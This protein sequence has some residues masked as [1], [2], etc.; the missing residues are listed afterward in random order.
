MELHMPTSLRAAREIS[1]SSV[2]AEQ[3]RLIA[4]LNRPIGKSDVESRTLRHTWRPWTSFRLGWAFSSLGACLRRKSQ[5]AG[6]IAGPVIILYALPGFASAQNATWLAAPSTSDFNT[7]T[8]WTP[9]TVPTGT[10]TFGP[11]SISSLTFSQDTTVGALQFNAPNYTFEPTNAV[12]TIAIS[13]VGILVANPANSPTFN[14]YLSA[15]PIRKLEH[16]QHG[17]S[18]R[19]QYRSYSLP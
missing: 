17:D 7:P 14:V 9:A 6:R 5:I 16:G 1:H 2:L 4:F 8:N 10:A 12:R 3:G 11:S 18:Q 13:G 15:A 19:L